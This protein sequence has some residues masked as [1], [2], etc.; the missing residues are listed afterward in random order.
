MI[1]EEKVA[2]R[3]ESI[4]GE[5]RKIGKEKFLL[6]DTAGRQRMKN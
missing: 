6:K 1:H 3:R 4:K 5:M 2:E